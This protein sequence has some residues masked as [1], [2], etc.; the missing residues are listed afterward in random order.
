MITFACAIIAGFGWLLYKAAK[1]SMLRTALT[2]MAIGA[3][4]GL[5]ALAA[6]FRV[7]P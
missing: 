3:A 7:T 6:I 2:G 1:D 4:Y 5:L